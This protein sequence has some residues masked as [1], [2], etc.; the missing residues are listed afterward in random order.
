MIAKS[1]QS[2]GLRQTIIT[3][4]G[5]TL[6]TGL[7]AISIILISR[8]LGPASFGEFSVGFSIVM[9]LTR[10]SDAGLSASLLKFA[11]ST[12][13]R[14]QL[15]KYFSITIK[16]R[17]LLALAFAALGLVFYQQISQ[18][19]RLSNPN[20]VLVSLTFGIFTV[21]YEQLISMLQSLRQF[22]RAVVVNFLQASTK[23][24]GASF[25]FFTNQSSLISIYAWFIAA[26]VVPLLIYKQL[27][28]NWININL[29]KKF[30]TQFDQIVNMSKHTAITFI[31]SGIIEHV[32]IL[33]VQGYL[34]SFQT[35]LL[36]GVTRIAMLFS[37]L[38]MSLGHVLYPRVARYK[39]QTD[40]S[41]YFK[42][43]TV[44]SLLSFVGL[45]LFLPFSK[46]SILLTIGQEYT[47]GVTI[48]Y[49][50]LTAVF[51]AIATV[52]FAA[53]FY[54]F[55][56]PWYFSLTGAMQLIIAIIGNWVFVP[57]YGLM[58][59]AL[60]TLFIRVAVFI[61]T[62]A[63]AFILYRQKYPNKLVLR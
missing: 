62:A 31:S 63:L 41:A 56:A 13:K 35:G 24:I 19:F 46:L 54:S 47:S 9:I 43:A 14:D 52:P 33:F 5:N 15:N 10:L 51:T 21:F 42:K 50:L 34:T 37:L 38:S 55:D 22:E 27:L 28:P 36:A 25:Y 1:L 11:G 39:S 45:A 18:T 23:L 20:I 26:P 7:S 60:T 30:K 58:A 59:S 61:F 2:E 4:F 53:M 49:I 12:N 32:G 3:L 57:T 17:T 29:F 40:F 8:V 44:I 48:L 6:A 16:L